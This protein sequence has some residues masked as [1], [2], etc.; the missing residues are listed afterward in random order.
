M[1][2]KWKKGGCE[3]KRSQFGE[4]RQKDSRNKRERKLIKTGE[5]VK[6]KDR[7]IKQTKNRIMAKLKESYV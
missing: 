1:D 4:L 2:T 3:C 6:G 5:K 7:I